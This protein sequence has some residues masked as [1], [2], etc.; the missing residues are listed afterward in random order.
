MKNIT[1]SVR[2]ETAEWI[3]VYAARHQT[4]VSKYV[5]E[6]LDQK[7]E[8]ELGYEAA[9]EQFFSARPRRLK[10]SGRYPRRDEVHER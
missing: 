2:E 7:M 1:I 10:D 6:L 9:M 8:Q 3:R 4:S 5:G